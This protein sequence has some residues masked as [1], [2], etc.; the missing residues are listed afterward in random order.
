M[1]AGSSAASCSP[2]LPMKGSSTSTSSTSAVTNNQGAAF[3]QVATGTC[4]TSSAGQ[5][6]QADLHGVAGEKWVWA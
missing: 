2:T 6:R 1:P 5:H 4:T 3:S